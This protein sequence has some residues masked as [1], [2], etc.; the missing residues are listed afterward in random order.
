[1]FI[2]GA[3][4]LAPNTLLTE[5]GLRFLPGCSAQFDRLDIGKHALCAAAKKVLFDLDG[6]QD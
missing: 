4:I 1:V 5:L 3:V 2:A 6:D